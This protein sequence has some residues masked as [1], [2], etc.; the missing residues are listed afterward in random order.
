MTNWFKRNTTH[1]LVT[2]LLITLCLAYF[3]PVL[4]GKTLGQNDVT[5][6]ESTA[7]EI[8]D[9]KEKGT[10]IL[11]TNQIYA[12]MPAFQ[13]WVP[14]PYNATTWIVKAI[15]NSLPAPLGTILILILGA[16]LLFCVLKINPWLAATGA[17]AF[18]FS[19]YNIILL[20]AGH[21]NQLFAIAFF[22]PVLAGLILIFRGHYITG[23]AI[24]SFFLALEIRANHIQMT[25]Y[26]LIGILILVGIELYH[27]VKNKVISSFLKSISYAGA[28]TILA[29]MVN[30][31]SLWSTYDYS[32][33]TIR[34][35]AN[36]TQSTVEKAGNGTSKEW[37][38]QWS[39]G[40]GEC[41]TFL[42]PGA[43]GSIPGSDVAAQ[44]NV[45]KTFTGLGA[46]PDQAF[47][48]SQKLTP[49]YWGEKPFTEGSFYFGAVVCFLFILGLTI[50][51]SRLKWW[52][53]GTVILTMLLSFGKNWPLVS[54]FFFDYVPLYNKFRTVESILAVAGLC[55]P[56]LA[57]LG[58]QEISSIK[59]K[60]A[61]LKKI[62][63]SFYITFGISV[64]I[65]LAPTLFLSFRSSSHAELIANLAAAL[66]IDNATANSIGNALVAD[67]QSAAQSDAVRSCIFI[68][69]AFGLLWAYVKN[70][71]TFATLSFCFLAL[72]LTDLWSVDKRYLNKDTFM[73]KHE[74]QRP[75]PR[76][77]DHQIWQDKDPNYKV[78]DLT[79]SILSDATTPYFHKSIGGYSAAG[80]RR[81]D[82][83]VKNQFN[84]GINLNI[85]GM[86]NTKYIITSEPNAQ[87]LT[88]QSNPQ[89]C[90]HAWFVNKVKFVKNADE[91]MQAITT[92]SPKSE[93]IIDQQYKNFVHSKLPDTS[94]LNS[95][96][97]LTSYSPDLMVYNSTSKNNNIAVFSEMFYKKGWTMLI[98]GKE[99]PFFR[100]NY[101]LR[102][103]YI[104]AGNH[105]IEF[106]FHP[107]SYYYGEK[108]S[109]AGSILLGLLVL[110]ACYRKFN[111]IQGFNG[112]V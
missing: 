32:T 41:I 76:E 15:S 53:L 79:Q 31:S 26:L 111:F 108:I 74:T 17:I 60:P 86:M 64:A 8:N 7:T 3:N 73:A 33:E 2:A 39:Q 37:A 28:A 93:V 24:L 59:D 83:L 56:L 87:H 101:L 46:D 58:L 94:D 70:K 85:L 25:Y 14:Y 44:S 98:D 12:G 57:L 20:A 61:L 80:L 34:G 45:I 68:A 103:A 43:Y 96:I 22:A 9:Y 109:L 81:F 11:W 5:R 62:K 112:S 66:K 55:F 1:L 23:T 92:L 89:A 35:Q 36:L 40:V 110:G 95:S 106:I 99:T 104:P 63:I 47:Y 67:R 10:T 75:Q 30:A 16:Y 50:V 69:I 4:F 71:M 21:A 100:A 27:A 82:E 54:D 91:E 48:F 90:G 6:A 77:V 19:S 88:V 102:A 49:M 42:I 51:E 29:I 52:L 65:A 38:Y 84:K 72:I 18:T 78:I 13:L 105:K 107:K 97:S